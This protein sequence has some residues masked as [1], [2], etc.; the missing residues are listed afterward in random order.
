LTRATDT[1]DNRLANS[2]KFDEYKFAVARV[3]FAKKW[4]E[5]RKAAASERPARPPPTITISKFIPPLSPKGARLDKAS[6]RRG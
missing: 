1:V 6:A 2:L 5:R 3:P 4:E